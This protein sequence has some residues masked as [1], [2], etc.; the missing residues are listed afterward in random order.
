MII[1]YRVLN[2][3]ES[4]IFSALFLVVILFSICPFSALGAEDG[5]LK[6]QYWME[7]LVSSPAIG[8]DGTVYVGS[9]NCLYALNPDGT[10]KWRYETGW[11]VSSSPAIG[12]D[13]TVYVGSDDYCLYAL[14]PDGT[15]KWRYETEDAISS[16]PAI[17]ADGTVYVGSDDYCLYALNPD[18]TLKWRYETEDYVS[19]SP[20][21]GADGTIYVGSD[22][23]YLYALNPDGTLK[24]RYETGWYVSSSPAI[25]ADGTVYVGSGTYL[26]ALNPDGT[27]KWRYE[28]GG[29]MDSSPTIGADGTI[30][31][32]SDDHSLYA[33]NPDGTLKWRYETGWYVSSSP[34][35]G[36]DGT[37]YA[38][39]WDSYLYAINPDGTL[40]WRFYTGD[41]VFSS[42][43][44]GA[45][46]T[47]YA[48]SDYLYAI[49]SSSMGLAD[50]SWPMLG[51]D[52][53]HTGRQNNEGSNPSSPMLYTLTVTATHGS[54]SKSPNQNSYNQ[55]DSVTLT[56]LPDACYEFDSWS[57]ACS[58]A[59]STCALTM[60][61][62]KSVTATFK[63]KTQ[64]L[65]LNVQPS[66]ESGVIIKSPSKSVYECGE[67]VTL[68]ASASSGY[69]FK[70]WSG[71]CSGAST[72][73]TVTMD[74]NRTVTA[75]FE[76]DIFTITTHI[77]V[78]GSTGETATELTGGSS[79]GQ[80][81]L[82]P[83]SSTGYEAGT[84]VAVTASSLSSEY[85]FDH[86]EGD[87]TG[88]NPSMTITVAANI[89]ITAVFKKTGALSITPALIETIPN[90][91][92]GLSASGGSGSYSWSAEAGKLV[93]E[94]GPS[95]NYQAPASSGEYAVTLTDK[96]TGNTKEATVKVY[97]IISLTPEIAT[98][99][100][101]DEVSFA[102]QGGKKPYTAT[103]SKGNVKIED[104]DTLLFTA[105]SEEGKVTITVKDSLA[106]EIMASVSVISST[107]LICSPKTVTLSPSQDIKFRASGGKGDYSWSIS[108]GKLLS[109]KGEG[110]TYIAPDVSCP[111]DSPC[112]EITV[113][114]GA[115]NEANCSV[116]VI[117]S[118]GITPETASLILDTG[119]PV[120]FKAFGGVGPYKWQATSGRIEAD[121]DTARYY[122]EGQGEFDISAEDSM[123]QKV[124]A[125]VRVVSPPSITPSS[126]ILTMGETA[127]LSVTGGRAPYTWNAEAGDISA[128]KGASIGYTAPW[129]NGIYA[130]T[131]TDSLGN[132]ANTKVSVLGNLQVNPLKT[133]ASIGENVHLVALRGVEPYTWQDGI[134][135]REWNGSFQTAGRHEVTVKDAAGDI[136]LAVI[137][138]IKDEL[139][140]TPQTAYI[141]PGDPITFRVTGGTSPYAW[142]AEAGSLASV[143]GSM[144]GYI[145]PDE[146]GTYTITVKD[147]RDV[148]GKAQV[149][150]ASKVMSISGA[151]IKGEGLIRSGVIIDDVPRAER[152]VYADEKS[153]AE[154]SFP[155]EVPSDGREYNIYSAVIATFDDGSSFI[156]F[157]VNDMFNPF[158]I[159]EGGQFPAYSTASG[160]QSMVVDFYRGMLTGLK[161][162]LEFYVGYAPSDTD[163]QMGLVFTKDPYVIEI[164]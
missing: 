129:K 20:A 154:I 153:H 162:R 19:S 99:D 159:Y 38:G 69:R 32:G 39:S 55:G 101:G 89:D 1:F 116:L 83:S 46:G 48:G 79:I 82:S 146:P 160:G 76:P 22:D 138:V 17:G 49:Y 121:E 161:G 86:Y 148:A 47:V 57:G 92:T 137:V 127:H 51:H 130:V 81:T 67:T 68:T 118:F 102:I 13:G 8:A 23:H 141:Q 53:M 109:S 105:P 2:Y 31:V 85:I 65:T 45:D 125:I 3:K 14:N 96:K 132:S 110:V 5:T 113:S 158:V 36:A 91:N 124:K 41:D 164:K 16:S 93:P 37:V 25:G 54:I 15:L 43:A 74:S 34:A 27:L 100:I 4:R 80:I 115:G 52:I 140:V 58:G 120:E 73:C 63:K 42:P 122:A 11:Y 56:A 35:I 29:V 135:G 119:E 155:V 88:I 77:A 98:V 163:P 144:V 44:I 59:A 108:A 133:V 60:Y 50:S 156:A 142:T 149:T 9:G 72:A 21:I 123:G 40:K 33:L 75:I 84:K 139:S 117:S 64:S 107:P 66:S 78:I 111:E 30:Y 24:W 71:A 151:E 10:L 103:S 126:I 134:E 97:E 157:R 28:T 6:W 87:I 18:G 150:V 145:A 143:E 7:N 131:V 26:Y 95:V 94:D 136:A 90:G 112:Y 12:A 147:G 104:E 61:E 106:Q 114:D 70:G 152:M 128:T 62:N